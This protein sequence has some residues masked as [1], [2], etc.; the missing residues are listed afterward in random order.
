MVQITGFS[1]HDITISKHGPSNRRILD[2][3]NNWWNKEKVGARELYIFVMSMNIS[4]KAKEFQLVSLWS[5]TSF[6]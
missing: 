3:P 5:P 4:I 2:I 6:I 1:D